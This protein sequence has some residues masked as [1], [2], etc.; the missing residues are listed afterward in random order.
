MSATLLHQHRNLPQAQGWRTHRWKSGVGLLAV[1]SCA[2]S[3]G[4]R[5]EKVNFCYGLQASWLFMYIQLEQICSAHHTDGTL[6]RAIGP[7]LGGP[8]R[9]W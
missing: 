3:F 5:S 6:W 4:A 7:V 9:Y 8:K 2:H 1:S